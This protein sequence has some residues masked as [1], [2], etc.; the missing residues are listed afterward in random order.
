MYN[1]NNLVYYVLY[2]FTYEENFIVFII[3]YYNGHYNRTFKGIYI[4]ILLRNTDIWESSE[5]KA[6]LSV[7][8][9]VCIN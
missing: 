7:I 8:W 9:K 4:S 2:M 3:I 6:Q 1:H 5:Y